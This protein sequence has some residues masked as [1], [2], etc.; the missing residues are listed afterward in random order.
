[1]NVIFLGTPE[2]AVMALEKIHKSNHKIVA[3]VAQEDRPN[4]RGNKLTPPAVKVKALEL[5]LPVFQFKKIRQD[6]VEVLKNL[7]AD[8]SVSFFSQVSAL[9]PYPQ[10][11]IFLPGAT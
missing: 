4:G 5:G 10:V 9:V 8:I 2:F 6:G 11:N 3:V 7:N 1:M